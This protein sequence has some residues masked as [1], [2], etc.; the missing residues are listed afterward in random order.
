MSLPS[1]LT[2]REFAKFIEIIGGLVAI[3]TSSDPGWISAG[4][5]R[6]IEYT[7]PT[8]ETEEYTYKEGSTTVCVIR[9]TFTDSSKKNLS[10]VERIS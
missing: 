10:S 5:G 1:N 4:V 9:A 2:D 8:D 3:R 7:Y 6:K